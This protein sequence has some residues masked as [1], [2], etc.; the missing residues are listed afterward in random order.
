MYNN[1]KI[2]FN[3][4]KDILN[5]SKFS[6]DLNYN[7]LNAIHVLTKSSQTITVLYIVRFCSSYWSPA[8]RNSDNLV[9]FALATARTT[10]ACLSANCTITR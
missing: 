6:T 8:L 1:N 5:I 3:G 4:S 10:T 9:L 7:Y 2:E